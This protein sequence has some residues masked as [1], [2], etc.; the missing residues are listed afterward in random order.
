MGKGEIIMRLNAL[1][2]I[3]AG[4][5][6]CAF[7]VREEN[8][9]L[10]EFD[11]PGGVPPFDRITAAHYMPAFREG[12]RRQT[13]VVDAIA[14][15]S[16]APTFANTIEA[17]EL[18]GLFLEQT[19][20]IF[21]AM[22]AANTTPDLRRI[23]KEAASLLSS[24]RDAILF[25]EKLFA[26][27]KT[28]H[29]G[30]EKLS[31]APDQMH[32][33]EDYYRD[34]V[35]GGANLSAADKKA[36]AKLNEELSL[37]QV[38][39]DE[40]LLA[41]TNGW[42]LVITEKADLAGIPPAVVEAAAETAGERGRAGAWIFTLQRPSI[43]PFLQYA[44]RRDLRERIFTA[45]VTRCDNGNEHD[46]K[47][48]LSRIV[49]LRERKARLLG[50]A[51]F[52]DLALDDTM[53]KTPARVYDFL[54]RLWKPSIA[55]AK[56][57]AFDLQNMIRSEKGAFQLAPWDWWYYAE[58]LRREQYALDEE[59]LRPYFELERVR[60]GAFDVATKLWGITFE[61]RPDLPVYHPDVRVFEVKEADG[62]SI[63]ILYTD[64][65]PR[66][67]KRAGAWS[68]CLRTQRKLGGAVSPIIT[69]CG[70]FTKPT[71]DSPS[72]L[73]LEEVTTLFHEFGH[74]LHGLLSDVTYPSQSGWAVPKDFV[75]LPSQIMEKWAIDPEV[76]P[77]YAKHY[78][79]GE[80][81]PAELVEKIERSSRFNQGFTTTEYLAASF[82]DMDWHTV[83][84]S[85]ALDPTVFENASLARIGIIPEIVV[86]YRSPYFRHIFAGDYAAGY[87]SYDW[88][89]VL[90]ADAFDA[91][92][93]NGLFDRE[94][95]TDFRKN[96][97]SAGGTEDPTALYVRFRGAEPGIEPLLRRRGLK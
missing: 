31:L 89:E 5:F 54:N 40:N 4:I 93:E 43:I 37:L 57:E 45:Y 8:P 58:K 14:A 23:A 24:H 26:R 39:F 2:I 83:K 66:E 13:G 52:A 49:S 44:E 6:L 1:F 15:E 18:S 92:K 22:N 29:E 50:F 69:N 12:M 72:L 61:P 60:R 74:A 77:L 86:R 73:S 3:A 64:Y 76:L 34:F 97:L 84:D 46:N 79:T 67:G 59:M 7:D 62:R 90:D 81:M 28:L 20:N 42:E 51:A 11:T 82:L 87:Y 36:L 78:R 94:T 65:F 32:L 75:E 10:S 63:G 21:R 91:F 88:A 80:P 56:K 19:D 70:N 95:A 53:A 9:L 33:L 25:N 55:R 30:R 41:E 96:I 47:D 68:G 27:I 48:I 17:L 35:R 85:T 16:A 71:A 38:K